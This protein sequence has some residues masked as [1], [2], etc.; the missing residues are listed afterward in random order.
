MHLV[1]LGRFA[2]SGH[3]RLERM[4]KTPWRITPLA[5]DASPQAIAA[6]L[7]D[8]EAAVGMAW[9][10]QRPPAPK[11]KLLQVSAAGL[12]RVELASVPKGVTVCNAFG[13]EDAMAEFALMT[14]LLWAHQFLPIQETFRA[15][16]WASSSQGAAP[17]HGEVAGQTV[18]IIGTG[19]LGR[20]VAQRC[21]AI[22]AKVIGLNRSPITDPL[23]DERL[24]LDRLDAVLARC[25]FAVVCIGLTPQTQGLIG[26]KQLAAMKPAGVI[27]NLARGHVI[28]EAALYQACASK[29]IGGA[30]IDT[31]YRYPTPDDPNPRPS[32]FPFHEL[33]NVMMS[34]HTSAWTTGM[35]DRRWAQVA[36]NLDRFARGE[37]L[38]N[39]VTE[40]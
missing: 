20:A 23:Y 21:K 13:H 7:A 18:A 33:P 29:Q 34:P 15:G 4:L 5:D 30:V 28:D 36:H 3:S 26:A 16:S 22:G 25:D 24:G 8:A 32:A 9:D 11:M 10:S 40:T 31:W 35:L 17:P 19:R 1:L 14:M 6:A 37:P 27:I 38:I 12:D 2:L 39:K